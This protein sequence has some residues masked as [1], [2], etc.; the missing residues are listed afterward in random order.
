MSLQEKSISVQGANG[1]ISGI[2][3]SKSTSYSLFHLEQL[4]DRFRY[5][6]N[7]L[8]GKKV[9]IVGAGTIGNELAKNLVLSGVQDL[10]VIDFDVYKLENLPRSTLIEVEDIGQSKALTLAKRMALKSPFNIRTAAFE[11]DVAAL[12]WGFLE[13]FDL[14]YSAVD[15]I[16]ARY[17]INKGAYLLRKSHITMGTN[18]ADTNFLGE[19]AYIPPG[20][21]ACLECLWNIPASHEL[22][23]RIS[24]SALDELEE[25]Q[26]QVMCFSSVIAGLASYIGLRSLLGRIAE[27]DKS[28]IYPVNNIGI[29]ID[30]GIASVDLPLNVGLRHTYQE[31]PSQ[32][33]TIHGDGWDIPVPASIS[34]NRTSSRADLFRNIQKNYLYSDTTMYLDLVW[35]ELH[36]I[37]FNPNDPLPLLTLM[38]DD[39]EALLGDLLPEDHIYLVRGA[40]QEKLGIIR[41]RLL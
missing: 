36:T 9:L 41:L 27:T 13:Q 22:N 21:R 16:A 12:G 32:I 37:A 24:C 6:L 31:D 5:S 15:N 30:V 14:L 25:T 23:K 26:P 29:G 1:V 20:A 4:E 10:T 35:S 19:I 39:E 8:A 7:D 33:C 28:F 34:L 18:V 11:G 2:E 17:F 3:F 38:D 40:A